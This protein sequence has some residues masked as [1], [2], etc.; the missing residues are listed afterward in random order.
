MT[1][2]VHK[3]GEVLRAAR[4]TKGVDLSRVER[5]TKIRER[6]LVALERGDYRELPG[7]VY[8]RGFLRNYGAYLGLDAEYLIDLYR[9]ETSTAAAERTR[10]P[11]APRPIGRRASRAFVVTPGLIFAALLTVAVGAFVAYLGWEFV[12]FARTPELRILDPAGNVSSYPETS[13]TVR[14]VTAPNARVTVSNLRENPTVRADAEGVFSVTV[15]LVPGSN[16][17]R[18]VARDPVTN[19]DS[20]PE[21]RTV[22]VAGEVGASP[23]DATA[24]IEIAAPADGATLPSPVSV[25]G[26]ALPSSML[27]L[28][29]TLVEPASPGFALVDGAGTAIPVPGPAAPA[30]MMLSADASG[31]FSGSLGLPSGLWTIGIAAEGGDP[32]TRSV[33]VQQP[34]A[35]AAS[36]AVSGGDSYLE[37]IADDTPVADLSGT[38]LVDGRSV[39]LSA[40]RELRIRAG[41]AGAVQITVNG[42]IIGAMGDPGGVVEW[43]ITRTES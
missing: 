10:M 5:D 35:L 21:E 23:S 2:E 33:T 37:V 38:I 43:R 13:M 32:V 11:V 26:S 25:T 27:Q 36:I 16:I 29:T 6:Y 3:L 22:I 8:T 4:E 17:I 9:I 41:N 18:L 39:D 1:E 31:A 7:A 40:V 28:T 30:P 34:A 24:S 15:Q 20:E 14:G 19:R 12:N 42:I